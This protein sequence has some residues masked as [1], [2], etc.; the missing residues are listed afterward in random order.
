MK[1]STS[2]STPDFST[3]P[4]SGDSEELLRIRHSVST[5]S[6][7][8]ACSMPC[9][10]CAALLFSQYT[11]LSMH[12]RSFSGHT[13]VTGCW[14]SVHTMISLVQTFPIHTL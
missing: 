14:V 2:T 7:G 4:T 10:N 8:V 9:K 5:A 3:M 11:M 6:V 13:L 1:E 12:T